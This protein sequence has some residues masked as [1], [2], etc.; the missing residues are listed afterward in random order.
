[1][2]WLSELLTGYKYKFLF[3]L[4]PLDLTNLLN[5]V[6]ARGRP[7]VDFFRPHDNDSLEH[8]NVY[9]PLIAHGTF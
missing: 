3:L 1:M 7:I 9:S 8:E 4:C 2:G 5:A 6:P